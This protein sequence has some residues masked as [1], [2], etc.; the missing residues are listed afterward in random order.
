MFLD[1]SLELFYD[2]WGFLS[3]L[4]RTP[5]EV[6]RSLGEQ[7]RDIPAG[8]LEPSCR[9]PFRGEAAKPPASVAAV[10]AA[11]LEVDRIGLPPA[12]ASSLKH[13]ASDPLPD[14]ARLRH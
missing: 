4:R 12:L 5:P 7:L 14:G 9:R 11:M 10:A 1:D 8:P 6:A 2:Q 13:L 3:G